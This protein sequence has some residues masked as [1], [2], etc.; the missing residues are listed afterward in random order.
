VRAPAKSTGIGARAQIVHESRKMAAEAGAIS[1]VRL[2]LHVDA[3]Y[4]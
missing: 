3:A 2:S 4:P 1:A